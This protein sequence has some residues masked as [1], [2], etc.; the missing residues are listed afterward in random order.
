MSGGCLSDS[1]IQ[2]G[3]CLGGLKE[4]FVSELK[5]LSKYDIKMLIIEMKRRSP[6]LDRVGG[7]L[8]VLPS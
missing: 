7:S 6:G 8:V 4:L 1:G 2:T 5:R 3:C